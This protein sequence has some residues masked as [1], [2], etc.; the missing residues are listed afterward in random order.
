[1]FLGTRLGTQEPKLP[2]KSSSDRRWLEQHGGKWRVTLAVPRELHKQLGTRLKRPLH[3]DSL[4]VANRLKFQALSEMRAEIEHAMEVRL[5]RPRAVIREAVEIASYYRDAT[6]HEDIKGLLDMI[7]HRTDDIKGPEVGAIIVPETG[8]REPIYDPKRVAL[9]TDF[10]VVARGQA[11]PL[12]LHH[13]RYMEASGVKPRTRADDVRALRYLS[14]WCQKKGLPLT[15]ESIS[16]RVAIRFMDDLRE[17]TGGLEPITQNKYLGR[18]S[19]YW[20]HLIKREVTEINVWAGLSVK[21]APP[22]HNEQ[23][24]AFL[25]EEVRQLLI[26]PAPQKLRDLMM[27][28]ALTG[29]RL[30]A[31][32]DLKVRDAIDDAF[33]FKPQ[34][35][36]AA[37]RDI[38]IHPDLKEIVERRSRGK[39][40]SD[41][42]F[43]EWPAPKKVG[44]ARE[45]SFKASNQFT[46]YRREC[47][48]NEVIPGKRR[49]LVN[50][51]SFRRW[52]ITKA[53]RAGQDADLIAAIVG[54]KRSGMTFG[55]YSEGPEMKRARKCVASVKLPPLDQGPVKEARALTPRRRPS[56]ESGTSVTAI[57]KG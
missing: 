7:A 54:H 13:D 38:P 24:R 50:F 19:R 14:D 18:L 27:M 16:K 15:V 41:D 29:A 57:S 11:T 2:R 37:A 36:E 10:D 8:V 32:V 34:K 4:A 52:F 9:A 28:G 23:E 30:D 26:G 22:K 47:G 40:P 17:L 39:A 33:T 51:H 21:A 6:E 31:I 1:M 49:S 42:L 43:P 5:G 53:E 12:A 44:S 46:D 45:R 35:R 55:R 48:V 56:P 25:D 3:T 20:Q